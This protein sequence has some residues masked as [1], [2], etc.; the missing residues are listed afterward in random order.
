MAVSLDY[1]CYEEQERIYYKIQ[2]NALVEA[3]CTHSLESL[4]SYVRA[5][6]V[7]STRQTVRKKQ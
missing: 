3:G 4:A 6:T 1:W 5:Q 7:G 2:P